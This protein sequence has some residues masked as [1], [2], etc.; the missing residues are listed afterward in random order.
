M[1]RELNTLNS[2]KLTVEDLSSLKSEIDD[3][4]YTLKDYISS[5][6]T[7]KSSSIITDLSNKLDEVN[8]YI[9]DVIESKSTREEDLI[10]VTSENIENR[11]KDLLTNIETLK[12]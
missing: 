5:N 1:S 2:T 7:E 11:F 3:L 4:Q 10:K 12:T 8:N 6:S 9:K